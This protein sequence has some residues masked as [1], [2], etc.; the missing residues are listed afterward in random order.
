MNRFAKRVALGLVICGSFSGTAQAVESGAPEQ[1][2]TRLDAVGYELQ[3]R[4]SAAFRDTTKAEQSGY[5]ELVE[6]FS[7]N[8]HTPI[9]VDDKG[10][11]AK[12]L[13]AIKTLG[14]ADEYGLN[15]N[16]YDT[17]AAAIS[18][19]MSMPSAEWLADAEMR[20]NRAVLKYARDARTGRPAIS[21]LSRNYNPAEDL[22]DLRKILQTF[23]KLEDPVSYLLDFHPKHPQFVA[24]RKLLLEARGGPVTEEKRIIVP[25]GPN[26]KPGQQ[27]ETIAILR[28]RM[29]I[30]VPVRAGQPVFGAD[31]YDSV[32]EG[33][34][35]TFQGRSGLRSDGVVGPA[36]RQALNG[37]S[38]KSQNRIKLILANMERWRWLPHDLGDLHVR[39]NIP[40]FLVRV[41]DKGKDILT[42]RVVVGKTYYQTPIF[43]AQMDHLVFHPY[44]NVPNSIKRAE[45]LP[46]LKN[47]GGG[48]WFNFSGRPRILRTYNLYIKRD[49]REID[50]NSVNWRSADI[51]QYHFYQ[52]PGG[53]NVLGTVKFMF[54]NKHDVYMHD[55]QE[56]FYFARTNRTYSHGCVRVQNPRHLAEVILGRNKGWSKNRTGR[57]FAGGNNNHVGLSKKIPVHFTYF[58]A[59]IDGKGKLRIFGDPYGHDS[60]MASALTL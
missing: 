34:V 44:W 42:E 37:K 41:I 47:G 33:A 22:P 10:L 36:T 5:G 28:Q 51:T 55:T 17:P 58:T 8:N 18:A 6:Y 54:P 30:P 13:A 50:P 27:H 15:P 21:N 31:F 2:I 57:A 1:L 38:S 20:I 7:D 35:R 26:L 24:L 59:W 16:H 49:G 19:V 52:P 4:L 25:Q 32:L 40:E 60:R 9:W 29:K 23:A 56:K 43:S 53:L 3:Q 46:Y 48:G 11:N 14:R 39:V 45:I 12:A